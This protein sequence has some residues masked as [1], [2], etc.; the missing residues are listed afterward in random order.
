MHPPAIT[1]ETLDLSFKIYLMYKFAHDS[2]INQFT[3]G[4]YI[5]LHTC[6]IILQEMLQYE[7]DF[8]HVSYNLKDNLPGQG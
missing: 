3:K 2:H 1:T 5:L 6:A 4:I 8:A 7:A